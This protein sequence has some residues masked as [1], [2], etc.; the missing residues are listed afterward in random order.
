MSMG[1]RTPGPNF[2]FARM[3]NNTTAYFLGTGVTTVVPTAVKSKLPVMNDLA[4]R[5]EP[6][7]LVQDGEHHD[8][9]VTLNRFDWSLLQSIRALE[10]GT[11]AGGTG[12]NAAAGLESSL[13]RG[14]LVLGLT[15]FEL[16]IVYQYANTPSVGIG[17]GPADLPAGR[18]YYSTN[19]ATYR[20]SCEGTRVLE[21]ACVFNCLPLFIGGTSGGVA[22][23]GGF[24]TYTE[25]ASLAGLGSLAPVV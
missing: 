3:R 16:I 5:S 4:G 19:L 24:K 18:L 14:T 1:M 23:F 17:V 20:E 6:F 9:A 25:P 21:V 11:P 12:G 22:N 7:Q 2:V 8:V 10:S 15:D 13:A